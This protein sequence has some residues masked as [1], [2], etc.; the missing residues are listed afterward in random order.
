MIPH[1]APTLRGYQR[2]WLR[3]DILAGLAAGTVV[4]PQAMA[5]ATIAGLP[6]EVG[7]Y[8][9]L[10]PM[11][12]YALVGGARAVS[13]STT[14]TIAVLVATTLAGLEIGDQDELLGAAFTLTFLV[15]LCLLAMRLFRLG[16]LV[17]SISPATLTGVRIGVGLTVAASQLPA[18]LGVA[19]DPD[20][21]G[22]F[23]TVADAIGRVPDADPATVLVSAA[24]V[25]V[26][27]VLRRWAPQVPGPLVVVA[28]AVVLVATTDV[29]RTVGL[30]DPVPSGLPGLSLPV[31]GDAVDL[32]PGALAIAVM[33]FLETVLVAR[34]NRR[35]DE[36]PIDTDQELLATGI[37]SLAGGLT[38][39]LPPAG[40]FSQSAVNLRSGARTQL[41]TVVTAA[42]ALLVALLLAP[43]LDDLPRAVLAAMVL[44][45]ILG[46]LDPRELVVYARIDRAELW[47]ALV[48]AALGLTGG[49]LLGVAVGVALTLVLV[50]RSVNQPRVAPS[51]DG[52]PDALSLRL[53][54][55]LYTGNARS[56]HD[57][58]LRLVRAADPAR[59]VLDAAAVTRVTIPLI[60]TVRA[61]RDE[62]AGDGIALTL[63]GLRPEVLEVLRRSDWFVGAE[64]AG[65]LGAR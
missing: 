19:A 6:V 20:G 11:V 1:L 49:M 26:L 58:A 54:G 37:A 9:C 17:E 25:G 43:V 36:P 31:P 59:V 16:S 8:T 44:V 63:T 3:P 60:D 45:A 35:R 18:L 24:A 2:G 38:Q 29:E 56:T 5:Y 34:T 23:A 48:V 42:L 14:S 30:I 46:L 22:F 12:A 64:Q 61:L 27:L 57:E 4:V 50:V 21:G 13:V 28:G 47:V 65:L 52:P 51:Y 40:G 15:G 55:G 39:T 62:L 41:S 10:A 53:T 33:A 32:L 7:L